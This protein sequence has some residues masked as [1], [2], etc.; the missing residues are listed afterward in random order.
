MRRVVLHK[1]L[2]SVKTKAA[3]ATCDFVG[4]YA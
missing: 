3:A 2:L 1:L 4:F